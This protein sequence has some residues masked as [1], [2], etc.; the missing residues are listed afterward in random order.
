LEVGSQLRPPN[1]LGL[2]LDCSCSDGLEL[3]FELGHSN[4]LEV[5]SQLFPPNRF[6][7]LGFGLDPHH[8]NELELGFG[9]A[10]LLQIESG[11]PKI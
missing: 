6:L 2:G 4:G 3:G 1:G 5:G 10:L 11:H 9:W 8:Y 7:E